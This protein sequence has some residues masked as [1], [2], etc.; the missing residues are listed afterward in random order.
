MLVFLLR[1]LDAVRQRLDESLDV[2][3]RLFPLSTLDELIPLPREKLLDLLNPP[4]HLQDADSTSNSEPPPSSLVYSASETSEGSQKER[5]EVLAY[6]ESVGNVG[7]RVVADEVNALSLRLERPSSH[8]NASSAMAGLRVLLSIAPESL[9]ASQR[10]TRGPVMNTV[11]SNLEPSDLKRDSLPSVS[12]DTQSLVEAYFARIHP[13]TPILDEKVFRETVAANLRTDPPWLGLLNM[14]YALGAIAC[15][16]CDS[17][18]D[19]YYYNK[20]K[21]HIGIDSFGSGHMETLQAFTLMSGYYLHYRNRP[22]MASAI[23]GA[24]FRMAYALD[25]HK[26]LPGPET[27]Q[28]LPQRELRRRIW[29]TLVVLDTGETTTL[30]RIPLMDAFAF[31]VNTPR[32]IDDSVSSLSLS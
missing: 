1:S 10:G 27:P 29:W 15:C 22:N 4:L 14:V 19:M 24:V 26:E 30:G 21:T 5:V 25:L 9:F 28:N 3:K 23:M 6:A 18:E 12:R 20:A 7:N 17:N 11:G 32:N 31:E 13:S 8:L 16:T 2:L